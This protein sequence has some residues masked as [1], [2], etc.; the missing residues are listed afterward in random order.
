MISTTSAT[1]PRCHRAVIAM[2]FAALA[3]GGKKEEPA[4]SPAPTPEATP[5]QRST[6][7]LPAPGQTGVYARR[8]GLVQEAGPDLN[9]ELVATTALAQVYLYDASG[10]PLAANDATGKL[11]YDGTVVTLTPSADGGSLEAKAT[12]PV[13]FL[14][15]ITVDRGGKSHSTSLRWT[16]AG[17]LEEKAP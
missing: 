1:Q 2:V 16:S 11:D 12:F 17:T 3:C 8:G 13:S 15:T 4:P 5:V 14:A 6:A 7:P 10:E 9:L